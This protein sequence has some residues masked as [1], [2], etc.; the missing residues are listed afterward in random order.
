MSE[1]SQNTVDKANNDTLFQ[2]GDQRLSITQLMQIARLGQAV[3]ALSP[4]ALARVEASR[5]WVMQT[6]GDIADAKANGN[7]PSAYYGINTGFGALA[8]R[9]ALDSTYLTKVLGR[10]L[11]ASHSVGVGPYF[12][13][14]VIRATLLIRAQS[15]AQ[16]YSGV[17]P[18]IINTLV[19]MLNNRVYPAVPEQGSLGASG[20]L[21]PL[22]HLLLVMCHAPQPDSADDIDLKLDT[23]DGEAFVPFV[24]SAVN[25]SQ[26]NA[27]TPPYFHLTQSPCT[28]EQTL[29]QRVSGTQ[30]MASVGGKIELQA[31]EALAL[32][33]GAT[34][35]AAIAALVV[36]DAQNLLD[37]AELVV[38]MTLEGIR[39]FRDPFYPHVH[40]ARGHLGAEKIA[41][42]ILLYVE[43]SQILDPGDLKTQPKRVP[44]QDPYSVRCAP[45]VLG[46]IRDTLDL[47]RQW[48]EMDL[49]AATDNPLIFLDLER[50][51]KT[52]SGG[53]FHGEPIAMAMDFLSI[54]LTE[55]GSISDR[56]MFNLIDYYPSKTYEDPVQKINP[57]HG[58]SG[59]LIDEPKITEGLNT[60]LMML[61]A[62]AAALVSDCKVLAHPDS[63]DSIPSSA[64]QEDHVSM[65]L[66]AALH[67]RKIVQNVENILALEFL[68]ATQAIGLQLA[69]HG[70]EDLQP[71]TGTKAAYD[72]MRAAG[73]EFLTQDRVLYPDIRK[74]LHLVRSGALVQAARQ[75]GA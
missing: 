38:A 15:L 60:G 6:V 59:F 14:E 51:Y 45:Q 61:Q 46:T 49:N 35:S 34:V 48:V 17:R 65:S 58:L 18:V 10:N 75:A 13:E 32:S 37:N 54:A 40:R 9:S 68:C 16:G 33:N 55:L 74:A 69:K 29:W 67:A 41:A 66:N 12:D 19:A 27:S 57:Q 53:N 2:V 3:M 7:K 31:K 23:T 20:D 62:T 25:T 63:V 21:A 39:G 11:I 64:N 24:P 70:N 56:R 72:C 1:N 43:G 22:C 42:Q 28:G 36:H 5:A 26:D 47:A 30:A 8:G 52:V 71:G 44:P 50:D 73:V 4:D